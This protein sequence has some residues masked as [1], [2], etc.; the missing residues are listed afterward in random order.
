MC[1]ISVRAWRWSRPKPHGSRLLALGLGRGGLAALA[2]GLDLGRLAFHVAAGLVAQHHDPLGVQELDDLLGLFRR[3]VGGQ[4]RIEL[5]EGDRAAILG[6]H[7]QPAQ[8]RVAL[9]DRFQPVAD[10]RLGRRLAAQRGCRTLDRLAH[11]HRARLPHD[12]LVP[13]QVRGGTALR[14]ATRSAVRPARLVVWFRA[15]ATIAVQ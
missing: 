7:H 1:S 10:M 9:Q 5:V 15:V 12:P 11:G 3:E 8:L 2:A 13:L 6:L 14:P 4:G